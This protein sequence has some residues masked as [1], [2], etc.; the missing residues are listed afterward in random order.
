MRVSWLSK[1]FEVLSW[2]AVGLAGLEA[3]CAARATRAARASRFRRGGR[4]RSRFRFRRRY[5]AG[6]AG[7]AAEDR[8]LA[9]RAA[10]KT[11]ALS[12]ITFMRACRWL[13]VC[14]CV[15]QTPLSGNGDG[16]QLDTRGCRVDV[17]GDYTKKK[18]V[19]RLNTLSGSE[20][21]LQAETADDMELWLGAVHQRA[22]A[23]EEAGR[24]GGVAGELPPTPLSAPAPGAGSAG[25]GP[26]G[27][28]LSPLPAH[29][30]IGIRNKFTS[31]RNRSPT[32]QSPVNKTRKPSQTDQL[33]SPKSKTWK[34]RVAK[35]LRKIQHGAGSPSSPTAPHPEGCTIG[36]P[37]E[38]C[39]PSNF[40]TFVP[41]LV[42][43]CTSVVDSRGLDIVGIYRVPGNTA[44][45]SALTESVNK[46]FEATS[47]QDPRWNDVNVISS[48]LKLFFRRLPNALLTS[49]L[50]PLFIDADKAEDPNERILTIKKLVHELPEHHFETLRYLLFHLKKVVEHCDSNKMEARNLAIV[51]GPTLVRTSD[52]NMV[53]MVTDMSHQCRIVE[54]LISHVDWFFSDE[55][56]APCNFPFSN[57]QD[58]QEL[59]AS[60]TNHNL[61]LSN[62]QKVEGMKADSANRDI[63]AKDIVSSIIS[64]ANRKMQKAKSR[65]GGTLVASAT[66]EESHEVLAEPVE[67]EPKQVSESKPKLREPEP[68]APVATA[69]SDE[70]LHQPS[71]AVASS[72]RES[73]LLSGS[74]VK[75]LNSGREEGGLEDE[76]CPEDSSPREPSPGAT[77]DANSSGPSIRRYVA[78]VPLAGDDAATIRTYTG[79]SATTQERIRRF[80]LETKAMLQR[81]QSRHRQE[82][83][84][85]EA[86][87]R[88]IEQ[89]W[90]QAKRDLES[91]DLLDKLADNPADLSRKGDS[92][93]RMPALLKPA[94]GTA[95]L[96]TPTL[97]G[98]QGTSGPPSPAAALLTRTLQQYQQQHAEPPPNRDVL[99]GSDE[100]DGSSSLQ[101]FT[102]TRKVG[103]T[104]FFPSSPGPKTSQPTALS[105][106][107]AVS[108]LVDAGYPPTAKSVARS[109]ELAAARSAQA[110][111]RNS[112]HSPSG[113]SRASE[114]EE[115][116]TKPS[117]VTTADSKSSTALSSSSQ[118][119]RLKT[120]NEQG[121][122]PSQTYGSLRSGSLDS[123][124]EAYTSDPATRPQ[125]DVSEDGGDLLASLTSTFDRKLKSLLTTS[126]SEAASPSDT[127]AETSLD[128]EPLLRHEVP[129]AQD[130]LEQERASPASAPSQSVAL[131]VSE[132]NE[133]ETEFCSPKAALEDT[134]APSE[135]LMGS[136]RSSPSLPPASAP[137]A[138]RRMAALERQS[139]VEQHLDAIDNK[140]KELQNC[141]SEER[142]DLQKK[143][144]E[145]ASLNEKEE[146]S[147]ED[148]ET[149][150]SKLKRSES[151][152]KAEKSESTVNTRLKRSESLTKAERED[153]GFSTS[154]LKRS[155]SLTK[156]EKVSSSSTKLRR[157]ESLTKAER[158]ESPSNMK[159]KRSDSL[160]KTEKTESN[161]SKRKQ[162]LL[163]SSGMGRASNRGCNKEKENMAINLTK[164]KRKNGM[165]ERSIKRRHTV[166]GTKDFDKLNWLDNR[167][168]HQLEENEAL[169]T[170][171]PVS[172]KERQCLRTSSPDLSSSRLGN[173]IMGHERF[174]I[175]IRMLSRGG[176]VMSELRHNI[177]HPPSSGMGRPHSLP[178]PNLA[179]RVFKVPLESHV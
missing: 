71:S 119:K 140:L 18:H 77:Q 34:G 166:G 136:K 137:S 111:M 80:E 143:V 121:P 44:A 90:Q 1:A 56:D 161:N 54:S 3:T 116:P 72:I 158:S 66:Q 100:R 127:V 79:L 154:R 59:E 164:L 8:S 96:Q 148:K 78:G 147:V 129:P 87:K 38:L 178:D 39:P 40:S 145:S 120:G 69:E 133:S 153:M 175:E 150:S 2:R 114:L 93:S 26:G 85:R 15:S 55:E 115:N 168:Q 138:P 47:L 64:A 179:S 135:D 170:N 13:E 70:S 31:F 165:P 49:E 142:E 91:E 7:R 53:T 20:V 169:A 46:G 174:L 123:L 33:P 12:L 19:L 68:L 104:H 128:T 139:R 130:P 62:I 125:S 84:R 109:V 141:R 65:K 16:E 106:M 10:E 57:P 63:S 172:N 105:S 110:S 88:R 61:L 36:V 28:R 14:F 177:A 21:L 17:A 76:A 95:Q 112:V 22:D 27:A 157:S 41:L 176:G 113:Q 173:T 126:V 42:E 43:L 144:K 146:K 73:V 5:G 25:A 149:A 29:K 102:H 37:L 134:G 162:D 131:K 50:Y 155:E 51:F 67:S 117:Q 124:Q 74:I 163:L 167:R 151:L 156:A 99:S 52:D 107:A 32:G 89:E 122:T 30:G 35:Q 82:L 83:E 11:D 58:V 60:S 81:D 4:H 6:A 75:S 45:V 103:G 118:L 94:P 86:E 152:S 48:L 24:K 171:A 23:Y 97:S 98:G 92:V 159:L 160:T 108:T 9:A 132:A 101:S